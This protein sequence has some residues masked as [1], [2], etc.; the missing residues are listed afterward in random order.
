MNYVVPQVQAINPVD[1][2]RA[3]VWNDET[4]YER[5]ILFVEVLTDHW[6]DII[7]KHHF[8]EDNENFPLIYDNREFFQVSKKNLYSMYTEGNLTGAFKQLHHLTNAHMNPG[9]Q[10]RVDNDGLPGEQ[11]NL[12][13]GQ[14]QHQLPRA[15]AA[16][17]AG[18]GGDNNAGNDANNELA[19]DPIVDSDAKNV[20][21]GRPRQRRCLNDN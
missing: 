12:P 4:S 9:D 14:H 8:V 15:L 18:E 1:E 21:G 11:D 6:I 17:M 20:D 5:I 7:V 3:P 2:G 10:Y 13:N 19:D 16:E